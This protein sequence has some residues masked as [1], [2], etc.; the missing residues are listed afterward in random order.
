MV[1]RMTSNLRFILKH[2]LGGWR[3]LLRA[4]R[5]QVFARI[6][7]RSVITVPWIDESVLTIKLGEK[8][9]T[10]NVYCGLHEYEEMRFVLDVLRP[11][12]TFVDV[13]A[14]GGSYTILA[15]AVCGSFTIAIEPGPQNFSILT[16]NISANGVSQL[17][18]AY[19]VALS[20]FV[21]YARLSGDSMPTA[22]LH[23]GN[24][25]PGDV[26]VEVQTLDK[27]VSKHGPRLLKFDVEGH[28]A[29]LI[30]GGQGVLASADVLAVIMEIVWEGNHLSRQSRE[31]IRLM[32]ALDF[33]TFHYDPQARRLVPHV[34][35][36]NFNIIFARDLVELE[37][38]TS[39]AGIT[40]V[41][42]DNRW[43]YSRTMNSGG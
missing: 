23:R 15:S 43:S 5:W 41:S 12:D 13:G 36:K 9:L 1:S 29:A 26:E 37:R 17:V 7:R 27:V 22:S 20:D 24:I 30:R 32:E 2:P 35:N 39:S 28:E 11:G 6:R 31:A 21:G 3:G 18:C 34:S 14:N 25:A 19:E 4:V 40:R 42:A 16:R 8:G 38:R 10:G 33:R